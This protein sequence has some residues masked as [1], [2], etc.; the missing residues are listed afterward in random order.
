MDKGAPNF[1]MVANS[2]GIANF[3][4][5]TSSDLEENLDVALNYSGPALL[6]IVVTEDENCYPMVAPGKSNSQM[7]GI[8]K[9][10]EEI[11]KV[12]N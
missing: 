5:E 10:N 2:Y 12:V 6:E 9:R 4:F 11:N 3:K 1:G 8:F 7:M